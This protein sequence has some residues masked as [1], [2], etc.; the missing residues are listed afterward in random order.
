MPCLSREHYDM[1][2]DIIDKSEAYP[3]NEKQQLVNTITGLYTASKQRKEQ[4]DA[5]R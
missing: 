3:D 1:L 2:M 5:N 4:Q